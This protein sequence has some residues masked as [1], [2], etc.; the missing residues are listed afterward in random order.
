MTLTS[1]SCSTN[2]TSSDA[3][4]AE[5]L[6]HIEAFI[7]TR[8]ENLA[9]AK[10]HKAEDDWLKEAINDGRL[11]PWFDKWANEYDCPGVKWQRTETRRWGERHYSQELQDQ[12]T[13]F[14]ENNECPV[15]ISW[16]AKIK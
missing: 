7:K 1:N 12:I 15:T 16:K 14:K 3:F 5:V 6:A 4:D 13:Q 9:T 10:A 2:N 11:E 8:A